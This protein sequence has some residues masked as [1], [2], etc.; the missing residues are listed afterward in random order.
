VFHSSDFTASF[1]NGSPG[2]PVRW[3][4]ASIRPGST[5]LV[6]RSIRRAPGGGG[7]NPEA[8]PAMR[9]STTVMVEGP[10]AG[11]AGSVMRCPAWMTRV[12]AAAGA[13]ASSARRKRRR[14]SMRR[15]L[16]KQ[17]HSMLRRGAV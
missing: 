6:E 7:F 5:V 11:R 16:V 4:W 14:F 1:Q 15:P 13:A 12:S 10:T 9:P 2:D 17:A 3:T 8:M